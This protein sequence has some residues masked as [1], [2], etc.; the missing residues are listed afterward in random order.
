M[1]LYAALQVHLK[2]ASQSIIGTKCRCHAVNAMAETYSA[3]SVISIN[4]LAMIPCVTKGTPV[5]LH[6][7]I[8]HV[9]TLG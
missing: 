6:R 1:I 7:A 8:L 4:L 3:D 9:L 2:Q 5:T